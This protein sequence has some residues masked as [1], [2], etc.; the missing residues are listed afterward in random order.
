MLA[1]WVPAQG[2]EDAGGRQA[3][4][5]QVM[6]PGYL[7]PDLGTPSKGRRLL[8]WRANIA[9]PDK[10][11]WL[12]VE[13]TV[14]SSAQSPAGNP[15][16][17]HCHDDELASA[18]KEFTGKRAQMGRGENVV[19]GTRPSCKASV[20]G[21]QDRVKVIENFQ[22]E[23]DCNGVYNH[24]ACWESYVHCRDDFSEI[25]RKCSVSLV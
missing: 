1:A 17:P 25:L 5:A 16:P 9:S 18:G 11:K 15:D 21:N 4:M 10:S 3:A 12:R 23:G 22:T 20:Y 14:E 8:V 24:R 6:R 19:R 13:P 2:P 7:S